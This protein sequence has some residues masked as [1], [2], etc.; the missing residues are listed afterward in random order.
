MHYCFLYFSKEMPTREKIREVMAPYNYE[1]YYESREVQPFYY[2]YFVIGGRYGGKLKLK[3][4]KDNET[5]RWEFT[6]RREGRLFYNSL[7]KKLMEVKELG[8]GF[9]IEDGCYDYFGYRDGFLYVDGAPLKDLINLDELSCYGYIGIN[10]ELH[11]REIW[12]DKEKEFVKVEH[13][14]EDL[15]LYIKHHMDCFV[16]VL[17]I[18]G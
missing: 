16:T 17:D 5:Y 12:K 1:N 11:T 13:F 10:G 7:I 9:Y 6:G 2:D 14:D 4:E 8:S 3:V 18:H 15:E